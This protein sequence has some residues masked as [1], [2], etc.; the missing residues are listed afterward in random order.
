M[1]VK[2]MK[3]SNCTY[4]AN[5]YLLLVLSDCRCKWLAIYDRK[6]SSNTDVTSLCD[7]VECVIDAQNALHRN[8][9]AYY[10]CL[11]VRNRA[12]MKEP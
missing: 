10:A 11:V 3:M 7:S 6:Y 9:W 8:G 4:H 5:D 12:A 2:L 1:E